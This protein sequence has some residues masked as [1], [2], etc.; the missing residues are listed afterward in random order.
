MAEYAEDAALLVQLVVVEWVHS[1]LHALNPA[2]GGFDLPLEL[3]LVVRRDA[4]LGAGAAPA[5]P[6]RR[7]ERPSLGWAAVGSFVRRAAAA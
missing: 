6:R 4:R 7:R 2:D 3:V 5:E 1:M